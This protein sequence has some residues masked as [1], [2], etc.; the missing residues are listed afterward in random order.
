MFRKDVSGDVTP[1]EFEHY[2]SPHFDNVANYFR[3]YVI[4]DACAFVIYF[5]YKNNLE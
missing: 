1:Y 2:V 3:K 4:P 5:A